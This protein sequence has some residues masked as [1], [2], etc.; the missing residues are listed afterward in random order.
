MSSLAARPNAPVPAQG[1]VSNKTSEAGD[2]AADPLEALLY[3]VFVANS[4]RMT[5]AELAGILAVPLPEL[6]VRA[7]RQGVPCLVVW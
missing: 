1:F 5:V 2:A 3:G 7:R 4:E 6:Q